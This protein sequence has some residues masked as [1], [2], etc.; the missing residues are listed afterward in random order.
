[1]SATIPHLRVL[2]VEDDAFVRSTLRRMLLALGSD[3][4]KEAADGTAALRIFE[5]NAFRPQL[6][7]CD[8]QMAPMDGLSFLRRLR[9][10]ADP[11]LAGTPVIMLTAVA[12]ETSIHDTV[13]LNISSYLLKPLSRDALAGR[14]NAIFRRATLSDSGPSAAPGP[15]Q[16]ALEVPAA[17]DFQDTPDF[18]AR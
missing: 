8:L 16:P 9:A 4:I 13:A 10:I 11:A 15:P 6:V 1:M 14:I 7:I 3:E 12:D 18:Q 17:P 2:L 5:E